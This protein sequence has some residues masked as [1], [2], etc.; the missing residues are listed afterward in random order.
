[1][2][3]ALSCAPVRALLRTHGLESTLM[4]RCAHGSAPVGALPLAQPTLWAPVW[5]NF[6]LICNIS[7]GL[8]D[9]AKVFAYLATHSQTNTYQSPQ[10]RWHSL[11]HS[12]PAQTS[13]RL[14]CWIVALRHYITWL[15]PRVRRFLWS[16]K[17]WSAPI[18]AGVALRSAS[19]PW[20]KSLER[21][22]MQC[23]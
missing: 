1:M 5:L 15:S 22:L 17:T 10:N 9:Y 20:R 2:R 3:V 6:A 19:Q 18:G 11:S 12:P 21:S 4:Q 23:A 13:Y 8:L 14:P 7:D 16:K